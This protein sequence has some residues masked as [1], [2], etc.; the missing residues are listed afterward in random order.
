MGEIMA[1]INEMME[2]ENLLEGNI[3]YELSLF[4]SKK[5][6]AAN[7]NGKKR[8]RVVIYLHWFKYTDD[9]TQVLNCIE[10]FFLL[11]RIC[12]ELKKLG[13][14]SDRFCF[15]CRCKDMAMEMLDLEEYERVGENIDE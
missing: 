9:F 7:W 1:Q 6:L 12:L 8:K 3:H 2:N 14:W 13:V 15:P 10:V 4:K 11:E 5:W